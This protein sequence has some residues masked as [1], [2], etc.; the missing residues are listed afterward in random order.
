MAAEGSLDYQAG[1][2]NL[3][4]HIAKRT[5]KEGTAFKLPALGWNRESAIAFVTE[6]V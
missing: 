2:S 5:K 1:K 3:R 4:L 6:P